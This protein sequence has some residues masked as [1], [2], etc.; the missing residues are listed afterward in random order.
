MCIVAAHTA[1]EN[2][3]LH[4]SLLAQYF[5]ISSSAGVL[6]QKWRGGLKEALYGW[7]QATAWHQDSFVMWLR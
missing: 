5:P 2:L 3:I 7:E 6:E 4:V 1:A